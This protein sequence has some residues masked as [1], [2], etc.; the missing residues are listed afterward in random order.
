MLKYMLDTCLYIYTIKRHPDTVREAFLRHHE[1]LCI[2]T[3]TLM[4]LV[5][6]ARCCVWLPDF[7]LQTIFNA[8]AEMGDASHE[9]TTTS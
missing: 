6:N 7:I 3:I 1:Q 5:T 2:S 4:E 9:S 8:A